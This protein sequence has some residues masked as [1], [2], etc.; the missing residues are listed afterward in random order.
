MCGYNVQLLNVTGE[1][2]RQRERMLV[3]G[4]CQAGIQT[5]WGRRRPLE[6]VLVVF[7]SGVRHFDQYPRC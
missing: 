5:I 7:P 1:P 2:W 4:H 6:D 3:E